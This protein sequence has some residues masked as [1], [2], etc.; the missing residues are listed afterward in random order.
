MASFF[1]EVFKDKASLGQAEV[2]I[3]HRIRPAT[4]SGSKPMIAR[5]QRLSAKDAI[6]Q[7][8]KKE[9]VLNFNRMKVKI[10]PDLTAE[11]SKRRAQFKDLRMK[12]HHAG[13]KHG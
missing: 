7:I 5:M 6:L 3:A 1:K 13:I 9:R 2:E 4:K 10:F 8:A 11:T 12:L